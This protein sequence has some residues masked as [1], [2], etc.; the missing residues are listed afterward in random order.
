[1]SY[2]HAMYQSPSKQL[3]I[4]YDYDSPLLPV[5]NKDRRIFLPSKRQRQ[6]FFDTAIKEVKG[7]GTH[8]MHEY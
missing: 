6:G 8:V 5:S 7:K 2:L 3:A 4:D 1:M